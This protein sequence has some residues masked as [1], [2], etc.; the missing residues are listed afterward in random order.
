M[1]DFPGIVV[2][3][4]LKTTKRR[5][6]RILIKHGDDT[7]LV[8][9]IEVVS[10]GNKSGK[11]FRDFT[12]KQERLL[13][14]EINLVIPIPLLPKDEDVPLN[15]RPIIENCYEMGGYDR[16]IDYKKSW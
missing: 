16:T 2:L 13:N 3:E 8:T 10:P 11:G 4:N 7:R 5:V 14:S 12:K 6:G 9:S 1:P 15:V